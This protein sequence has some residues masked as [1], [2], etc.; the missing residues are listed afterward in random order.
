[1]TASVTPQGIWCSASSRRRPRRRSTSD[2][3]SSDGG[4]RA[5]WPVLGRYVACAPPP[6]RPRP[7]F[8]NLSPYADKLFTP[9]QRLHA[10]AEF[11]GTGV[12]LATVQRIMERHG[13]RVWGEG[14]V[15]AGAAFHLTL[16]KRTP[17]RAMPDKESF[18]LVEDN[19]D[20]ELLTLRALK[21]NQIF[22]KVVVARDG[23][24]AL[25]Y[26][27]ATGAHDGR[28][29]RAQPQL[30]LL[31]L[32]L[33]RIDGL[34]VLRR[35]R[36]HEVTRLVPVVVLTSSKQDEDSSRATRSARTA[37]SGSRS[38]SLSSRRR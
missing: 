8:E 32:K 38:T 17:R 2:R 11:A 33:P 25:D 36:A 34:E 21:K 27:H 6:L 7:R 1:M 19:Q 23:V 24:D 29:L 26:L 12:G 3:P 30:V 15:G 13:G 5:S 28:D 9:F 18:L 10:S 20:D 22:N 31:D 35:M 4:Q 16:P 14:A 37:T